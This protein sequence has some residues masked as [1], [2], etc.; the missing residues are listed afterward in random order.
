LPNDREARR[1]PSQFRL[2]RCVRALDGRPLHRRVAR[3]GERGCA[4]RR[5]SVYASR[6]ARLTPYA[7][8][9]IANDVYEQ[10]SSK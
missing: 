3:P 1:E 2:P 6:G 8:D 5:A 9:L 7:Q 10:C 4:A